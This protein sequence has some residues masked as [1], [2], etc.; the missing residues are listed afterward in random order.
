MTLL[1]WLL[2]GVGV[3]V[4]TDWALMRA[5]KRITDAWDFRE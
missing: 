5:V 3:V 1:G 2:A 4:L